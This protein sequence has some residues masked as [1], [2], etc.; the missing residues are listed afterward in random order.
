MKK[1]GF[2]VVPMDLTN[3]KDYKKLI[4]ITKKLMETLQEKRKRTRFKRKRY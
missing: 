4:D 1:H 2:V 3:N